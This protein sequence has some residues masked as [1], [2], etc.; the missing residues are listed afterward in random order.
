MRASIDYGNNGSLV[1]V[2]YTNLLAHSLGIKATKDVFWTYDSRKVPGAWQG[3][4]KHGP[5]KNYT[6]LINYTHPQLDAIVATLTGPVVFGD[7]INYTNKSLLMSCCR[8]DGKILRASIS[9]LPIDAYFSNEK[10]R[11]PGG[12]VWVV[13]STGLGWY[14]VG[15]GIPGGYTLRSSDLFPKSSAAVHVYREFNWGTCQ[16]G[17]AWSECVKRWDNGVDSS[18]P[19]FP[20]GAPYP[21]YSNCSHTYMSIYPMLDVGFVLLGELSKYASVS[22]DRFTGVQGGSK[23]SVTV[24]GVAGET[25]D[26][27]A[28]VPSSAGKKVRVHR[29]VFKGDESTIQVNFH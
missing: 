27:T 1:N 12:H 11:Y 20:D 15:F 19:Y 18:A 21:A 5:I 23:L 13:S 14:V 2:A 29:V 24:H 22:T 9:L 7:A 6:G 26:V 4:G 10:G 28:L 25:V 17:A 16:D 3:W 8:T